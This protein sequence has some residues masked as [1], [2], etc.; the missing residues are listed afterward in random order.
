MSPSRIFAIAPPLAASGVTCSAAGALPE[1]PDKRPVGH[2]RD[3]EAAILQHA[4]RRHQLVQFRHAVGARPLEADDQH[5]VAV[6]FAGPERRLQFL[7]RVEHPRRRL[8]HMPLR[9][10]RRWS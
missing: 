5:D 8:D 10:P 2:Q 7:L 6:E 3:L 9:R 1:A 4:D